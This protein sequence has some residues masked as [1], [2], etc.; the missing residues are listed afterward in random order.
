M[1][2]N[3]ITKS[4]VTGFR[5]AASSQLGTGMPEKWIWR[6]STRGNPRQL[7]DALKDGPY[8]AGERTENKGNTGQRLT[9]AKSVGGDD[10]DLVNEVKGGGEEGAESVAWKGRA[11]GRCRSQGRTSLLVVG[12]KVNLFWPPRASLTNWLISAV[13]LRS[14]QFSGFLPPRAEEV[15]LLDHRALPCEGVG[16]R[17]CSRHQQPPT[18]SLREC[19]PPL[20]DPSCSC[21]WCWGWEPERPRRRCLQKLLTL[22]KQ[23]LNRKMHANQREACSSTEEEKLPRKWNM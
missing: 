1:T 15:A 9:R 22:P 2:K 18:W 23:N 16:G 20:V 12:K 3:S 5:A 10:R 14:P 4:D 21:M 19:G 8:Q 13:T 6:G 7:S 11:E 17:R